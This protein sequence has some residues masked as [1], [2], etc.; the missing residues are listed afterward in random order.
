MKVD[1]KCK[2]KEKM[3][4][5]DPFGFDKAINY[6]KLNDP[7]ILKQLEEIFNKEEKDADTDTDTDEE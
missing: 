5:K 1:H 6:D 3:N 4:K 7:K 2:Q